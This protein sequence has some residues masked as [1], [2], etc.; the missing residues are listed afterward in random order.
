MQAAED[1]LERRDL[2]QRVDGAEALLR[3]L[4]ER[5]ARL[6]VGDVGGPRRDLLARRIELGGAASRVAWVRAAIT[7]FAPSRSALATHSRPR[8][9]PTPVTMTVFPWRIMGAHPSTRR[10]E[11][12]PPRTAG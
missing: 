7:T 10:A 3:E 2:D 11:F 4:H 12:R 5:G 1:V 6:G 9:T 8:P